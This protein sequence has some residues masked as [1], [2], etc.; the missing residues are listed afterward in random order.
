MACLSWIQCLNSSLICS[1][2]LPSEICGCVH[3]DSISLLSRAILVCLLTRLYL[4]LHAKMHFVCINI[5]SLSPFFG[6][7]LCSR[8]LYNSVA[9]DF[10]ASAAQSCWLQIL[11]YM[12]I[13]CSLP[14][15]LL[16]PFLPSP[17]IGCS[18]QCQ[19]TCEFWDRPKYEER[20]GWENWVE[21]RCCHCWKL[22]HCHMF[23]LN[24]DLNMIIEMNSA[25]LMIFRMVL[26]KNFELWFLVWLKKMINK[27][28]FFLS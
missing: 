19:Y 4:S 20:P 21:V 12:A 18:L 1:Q 7:S 11:P 27:A 3:N 8:H 9:S 26:I 17:A 16:R 23:F 28:C 22:I 25:S 10:A 2:P 5:R 13:H 24:K 15:R 6:H 14:D